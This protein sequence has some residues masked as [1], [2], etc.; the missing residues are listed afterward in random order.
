MKFI[1][2]LIIDA[3]GMSTYLIPGLGEAGDLAWAPIQKMLVKQVTGVDSNL[4]LAEELI[5]F[6]D[7]IPSATISYFMSK[8]NN[9]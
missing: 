2:C 6:T 5:P 8:K 7:I 3:L 1:M 4:V 9:N